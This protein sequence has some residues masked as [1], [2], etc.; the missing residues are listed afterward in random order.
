M[1]LFEEKISI[2]VLLF[3]IFEIFYICLVCRATL[4]FT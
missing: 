1:F 2:G 4:H 3:N